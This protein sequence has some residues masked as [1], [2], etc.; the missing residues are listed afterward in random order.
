MAAKETILRLH[1]YP[2]LGRLRLNEI[3]DLQ[4]QRLKRHLD[5]KS[6]KTKACVLAQLET[7]LKTAE[8]WDEITKAP[9]IDL[10]QVPDVGM[11]FY[12][13]EEWETLVE[14]ARRAG[15]MVLCA[16]L[17]GGEAG[18]RRGELVALERSDVGRVS[19]H[20]LRSEWE[21][22]T[23]STKGGKSRT[24]PLTPRLLAALDAARHL[25]GKRLLW[26][27]NG[28]KVG[29]PTLQSWLE[30]ACRR[31]GL[32]ES[33]NLNKLR[34]T[35]CSHLAMLGAPVKTIQELAGH[36]DLKTT[37][38]YMHLSQGSKDAAIALLARGAGVE[39]QSNRGRK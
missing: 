30:T 4:I 21:G 27:A 13:F 19:V 31:A 28:H 9:H 35:F 3:G 5:G 12:D 26:Q 20:V 32:P 22:H 10:P 37:M 36:A 24:V 7:I 8:R 17:L 16:V 2:S 18:L 1:L 14:G 11:S 39:Q 15:P 23:G 29:V 33:R 38:R 25:R 6:A 34:H